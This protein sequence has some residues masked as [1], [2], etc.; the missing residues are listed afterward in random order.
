VIIALKSLYLDV[1]VL[2]ILILHLRIGSDLDRSSPKQ[3]LRCLVGYRTE[4]E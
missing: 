2:S 1:D 4:E 3:M